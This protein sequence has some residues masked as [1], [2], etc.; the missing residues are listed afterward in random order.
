MKDFII[1]TL[2][3]IEPPVITSIF[4][5]Y[6]NVSGNFADY[7]VPLDFSDVVLTCNVFGWPPPSVEWVTMSL[8]PNMASQSVQ[9]LVYTS[10]TLR[11]PGG[12]LQEN[13]A[14]Y[15][16]HVRNKNVTMQS[17]PINLN[18]SM[19]PVAVNVTE[20]SCEVTASSLSFQFRVLT[21]DCSRWNGQT[22]DSILDE[23][24]NVVGGG[25][26]SQ[27]HDCAVDVSL[28]GPHC[29]EFIEGASVFRGRIM[30]E[31]QSS[32]EATYCALFNWWGFRPIIRINTRFWPVDPTCFVRIQH[33]DNVE[34]LKS[35]SSAVVVAGTSVGV[36]LV[37]M[38]VFG[39]I[40][41]CCVIIV[42]RK[43]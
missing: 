14:M 9:S 31:D 2:I 28:E 25:I 6:P 35:L 4:P 33:G 11:F 15:F 18:H 16:C 7:S 10:T 27:C 26:R 34:C 5:S 19:G 13:S 29:S 17:I 24:L 40:A 23:M 3:L 12:F 30:Y 42:R 36:V 41:V 21:E 1:I 22:K 43:K 37:L 20:T 39:V 38:V 8:S 32:T